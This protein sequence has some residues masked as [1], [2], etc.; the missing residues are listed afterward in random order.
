MSTVDISAVMDATKRLSDAYAA[1]R[2]AVANLK[3]VRELCGQQ[4][5]SISING[6]RVPVAGMDRRTY[7]S[8]LIRGREMIHLGALKAL[9]GIVD[10]WTSEVAKRERELAALTIHG[11]AA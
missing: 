9:Q 4:G 10:H 3:H 1:R 11:G 8:K 7:N 6:I 5:Y 2:E